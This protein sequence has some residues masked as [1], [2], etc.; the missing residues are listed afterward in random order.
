M[1]RSYPTDVV[2][3]DRETVTFARFSR[4]KAREIVQAKNYR[5]PGTFSDAAVTPSLSNPAAL[6]EL[7]RRIKSDHG[8]VE[9][10]A[11]LLPDSWFRMNLLELAELPD[12]RSEADAVVRWAL[13]RTLPI[14]PE[15]LRLTYQLVHRGEKK[16]KV[17]AISAIAVTLDAIEQAFA[18]AEIQ[19][20]VIEPL[21]LNLWNAI[22]VREP[23]T[24]RDR[25]FFHV[26]EREFTSGVFRGTEPLF[27]R[28]R[29][30]SGDRTVSQEIK[31]SASYLRENLRLGEVETC[32]LASS[33][34]PAVADVIRDEFKAPI[35]ELRLREFAAVAP[36]IEFAPIESEL[37]AC[38]GVFAE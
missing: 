11:L 19:T 26:R 16:K 12:R 7:L 5:L 10:V 9:R 36:G 33:S 29:N 15:Q 4:G 37:I 14:A 18:E 23:G 25:I 20:P 34:T 24:T 28:S 2:I 30:L 3:L 22:A 8:G 31:L 27:I 32:Y 17:L 13:K 35:R 6:V 1:L 21:G 38:S